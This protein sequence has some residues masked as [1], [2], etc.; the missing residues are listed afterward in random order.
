MSLSA[1]NI[2]LQRHTKTVLHDISLEAKPGEIVALLG[3]NGAGKSTLLQVLSGELLAQSGNVQINNRP[4]SEWSLTD[5]AQ[6]IAV[7]PQLEALNFPLTVQEVV[8]LGRIPHAT[9]P[10]EN[11]L[12]VEKCLQ[13][14]DMLTAKDRQYGW[15]SGGERQ[16]VQIARVLAQIIQPTTECDRYLLLDEPTSALD[17]SHQHLLLKLL[18]HLTTERVGVV[19]TLHDLNL[20]MQYADRVVLLHEGKWVAEGTPAAVL[21]AQNI[22]KVFN[23]LVTLIAHP[24]LPNRLVIMGQA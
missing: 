7:L 14:M 19:I 23:L 22:F 12:I 5:I 15:L 9:L 18:R 11:A 2:T 10:K 1:Q 20:A 13:D 4:R 21:T 3:P 24:T 8:M 16:R 6:I 17:L